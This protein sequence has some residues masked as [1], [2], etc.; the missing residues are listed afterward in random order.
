MRGFGAVGMVYTSSE[1][2]IVEPLL[3]ASKLAPSEAPL[4]QFKLIPLE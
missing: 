1:S 3:L 4:A 2:T